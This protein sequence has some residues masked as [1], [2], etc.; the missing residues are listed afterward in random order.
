MDVAIRLMTPDD[1]DVVARLHARSWQSAYRGIFDDRFLDG[2]VVSERLAAWRERMSQAPD[3]EF[4]FLALVDGV[5]AGFI[6]LR[7]ASDPEWGTMLDNLHVLPEHRGTGIGRRLIAAGMRE[8]LARMRQEDGVWLWV[9][10]ANVAA[11]RV[12]AHLGGR[13]VEWCDESAA[14]GSRLAKWRVAWPSA[15][16]LLARSADSD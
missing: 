6:R 14:D 1:A 4:G 7:V 10:E 12:Y 5:P 9:Y 8:C 15:R 11:R 2:P 3:D 16:Q 13:E